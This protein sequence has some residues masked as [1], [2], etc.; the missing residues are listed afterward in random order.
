MFDIAEF[1]DEYDIDLTINYTNE[2]VV[3]TYDNTVAG[4]DLSILFKEIKILESKR[5]L[6]KLFDSMEQTK[7]VK[8]AIALCLNI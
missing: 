4:D 1:C 6:L 5:M 3:D 7:T 8:K 2:W